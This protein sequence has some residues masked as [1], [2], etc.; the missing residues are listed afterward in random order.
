MNLSFRSPFLYF[1][2]QHGAEKAV[3]EELLQ[4]GSPYRL[5]YSQK[6]FVTLKSNLSTPC[7]SKSLPRHPLIRVSGHVL[8]RFDGEVAEPMV[9]QILG[10]FASLDWDHM[11][12]W[13]RDIAQPGW[14]GFEPGRSALSAFVVEKFNEQLAKIPD[15]RR[16]SAFDFLSHGKKI[17]EVIIDEPNRWWVGARPVESVEDGWPGGIYNIPIPQDMVSRAYL[18]L[19]EAVAW[20]Q[21]PIGPGSKVVEIGSSPG[22]ACQFLLDLGAKVTGIDPAEMDERVANHPAYTHWRSRSIQV[23]RK[24][25][26]GFHFLVCDANVAPNYTLDTVE[27]IV[28][29]PTSRMEGLLLTIK[30]STWE[31]AKWIPDH[32]ERVRSWGFSTVKARQLAHNRREYCLAA[33]R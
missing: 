1:S 33:K 22:G 23:K 32:L 26:S 18:K 3:K 6:G 29:Y 13:Q 11:H 5:A 25:F 30:L 4:E 7:W 17:L 20:S 24:E 10:E 21:M 31:H 27:A 15:P 16:A 14:N 9:E 2:C 12:V 8:K 28:T 19:A